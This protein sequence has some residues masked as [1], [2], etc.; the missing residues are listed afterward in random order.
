MNQAV[1]SCGGGG[2]DTTLGNAH[3]VEDYL[4]RTTTMY[5]IIAV[6][7]TCSLN[8]LVRPSSGAGGNW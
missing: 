4:A 5:R 1:S 3:V 7:G 6:G 8:Q 2:S